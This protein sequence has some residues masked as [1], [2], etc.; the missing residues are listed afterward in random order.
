MED[1]KWPTTQLRRDGDYGLAA[2]YNLQVRTWYGFVLET[3]AKVSTFEAIGLKQE[4]LLRY[5]MET[6]SRESVG[7]SYWK[8]G[9]IIGE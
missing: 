3:S 2:K 6:F 8:Q 5:E 1:L 7:I 9:Q 4:K